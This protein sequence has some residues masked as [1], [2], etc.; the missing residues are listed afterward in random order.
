LPL[1]VQSVPRFV[2]PAMT[3]ITIMME[4]DLIPEKQKEEVGLP[5]TSLNY[6]LVMDHKLFA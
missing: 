4:K 3:T 2:V 1:V 5:P 6:I